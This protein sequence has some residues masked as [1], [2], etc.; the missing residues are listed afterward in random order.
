[1][2]N[3]AMTILKYENYMKNRIAES[4]CKE[5]E[6]ILQMWAEKASGW[7]WL[8]DKAVRHYNTASNRIMYPTL[9]ISTLAGGIGLIIAGGRCDHDYSTYI[10]YIVAGSHI[11]CSTLT[12]LNRYLRSNEK[13][14]IHMHMNKSFSSFARKIVL[15]L[16][17]SPEDRRDAIEFCKSC[18]DEYDKLVTDSLLMPEKVIY[19]FKLKF[20]DAKF[21]PE[22]C[23]GLIHFTNYY[24]TKRQS[25]DIELKKGKKE[26]K[27]EEEEKELNKINIHIDS[28]GDRRISIIE[29]DEKKK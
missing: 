20:P 2:E 7:A 26:E 3:D 15:E 13:A 6:E 24:N 10:E 28:V 22:V 23:N 12:T 29:T 18:R 25:L 8:H 17:L 9:I 16:T 14:E 5:Q 4:W 1:M 21:K 11:L 27:K 19:E